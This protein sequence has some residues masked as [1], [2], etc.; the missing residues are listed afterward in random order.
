MIMFPTLLPIEL[1]S[2]STLVKHYPSYSTEV[3]WFVAE[4]NG[5]TIHKPVV[6]AGELGDVL[7]LMERHF[8]VGLVDP[9][10]PAPERLSQLQEDNG[11][12][13]QFFVLDIKHNIQ[14]I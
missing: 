14:V 11:N 3:Q 8:D 4:L 1:A 5:N 6:L 10:E 2:L 9:N 13:V 12:V 7:G